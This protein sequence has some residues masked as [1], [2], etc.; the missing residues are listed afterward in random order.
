MALTRIPARQTILVASIITYIYAD[1]GLGKTSLSFTSK[2]PIVFDFDK[3]VHRAGKMRRGDTVRIES[4]TDVADIEKSDLEGIDTIV[5]DTAGRMIECIKTHLAL[6][7]KNRQADGS[8]KLKA[9]GVAGEIFRSWLERI[10]SYGMDVVLIAHAAE[11]DKG[12]S[13]IIRPD[14]GGKNQGELYK[15]ADLMGYMTNVEGDTNKPVRIIDF[16]PNVAYLAKNSGNLGRVVV[17]DLAV[18][19]TYLADLINQ[20]KE[21]INSMTEEQVKEM[22]DIDDLT[23]WTHDCE[24]CE[25]AEDLNAMVQRL[26]KEHSRYTSMRKLIAAAAKKLD[27]TADKEKGVYVDNAFVPPAEELVEQVKLSPEA[28]A[29]LTFII[30][31]TLEADFVRAEQQIADLAKS[32][33]QPLLNAIQNR[34][35]E[36]EGHTQEFDAPIQ[37][38]V[39]EQLDESIPPAFMDEMDY[40]LKFVELKTV[41]EAD[42]LIKQIEDHPVKDERSRLLVKANRHRTTLLNQQQGN[43]A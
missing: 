10:K 33:R 30:E 31:S 21:F 37:N 29:I 6:N 20:A 27:V 39:Q 17:P 12:D 1:A 5:I 4:W 35:I 18:A 15:Q 9:H 8:L 43:A 24:L 11:V 13:K 2:N 32:D 42:A 23:N 34:R 16:V 3:G 38:Q 36:L 26:D 28:N 19:T 14:I 22:S 7:A 25:N 41:A 40:E